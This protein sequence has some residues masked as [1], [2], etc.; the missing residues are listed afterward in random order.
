M[1]NEAFSSPRHISRRTAIK[2]LTVAALALSGYGCAPSSSQPSVSPTPTVRPLGSVMYTYQGHTDRV[3]SVGWSPDGGRIVS[4]SLDKTVQVWG[5]TTGSHATIF[6]GHTG[7]VMTVAWSPDNKF[8][9]SGSLDTTVRVW[10]ITTGN[11]SNIYHGHTAQ[12]NAVAWSPDEKYIA[13]GSLDKTVQIWEPVAST[14]FYTYRGHTDEVTDVKWSPDGKYIASG[15]TDKTVQIWEATTGK[16]LYTYRGHTNKV[17]A[18]AWSPDGKYIASGSLDK[19]VQ[20]WEATTGTLL[21]TYSG[22]NVEAAKANP[23]KGVLPDLIFEVAWSHNGKHIA[24]VTQVYCG[25]ICAEV[26]FW[27]A[28]T[29]RNV[30][31]YPD[32]PVFALAWSPDDTRIVSAVAPSLAQITKAPS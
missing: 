29:G 30:S 11:A 4:G 25:D 20:V 28:T 27:D 21:Y 26:L 2:G 6:R 16:L 7:G 15:S 31:F 19:T 23:S 12:I 14:A 18:V 24:A 5:A 13:S 8:V 10:N 3:T 22:Y 1:K 9:V 17:T 32:F